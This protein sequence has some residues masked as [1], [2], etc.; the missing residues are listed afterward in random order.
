MLIFMEYCTEGTI[1]EVA[2]QGIPEALMRRY[3]K[4]ILI[5]VKELHDHGI[6]HRDIKGEGNLLQGIYLTLLYN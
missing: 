4:E 3:I 5:A 6:V 1:E 2:K